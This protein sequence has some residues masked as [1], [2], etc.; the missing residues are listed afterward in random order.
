MPVAQNQNGLA[1]AAS[2]YVYEVGTDA[3]DAGSTASVIVAAGIGSVVHKGDLIRFTSGALSG[4]EASVVDTSAN[5]VTLSEDLTVAPVALDAFKILRYI[6]PVVSNAGAISL[7]VT[8]SP[9]MFTLNGADQEVVED[10]VTPAN[11][12]P[13]PVKIFDSEGNTKANDPV[14]YVGTPVTT[15]AYVQL[16][17]ATTS[18]ANRIQIFDSSGE[19]LVMAFGAGGSETDQFMVPP[20]GIDLD[21]LIPASTRLSIK[22]VSANATSGEIVLN[23]LT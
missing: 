7:T 20:G 8:P 19:T 14:S 23:I 6:H 1:V 4:I 15:G 11:N 17:A 18:K 22:A 3:V 12:R 21:Y 13:L 2:L 5:S 9:I 10:A 16:V